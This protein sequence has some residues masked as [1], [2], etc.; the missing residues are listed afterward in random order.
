MNPFSSLF[1]TAQRNE[2]MN[3]LSGSLS[4]GNELRDPL[5]AQDLFSMDSPCGIGSPVEDRRASNTSLLLR[6]LEMATKNW[7]G[8]AKNFVVVAQTPGLGK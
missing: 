8:R 4:D 2:N 3:E 5:L 7:V 6:N 1:L